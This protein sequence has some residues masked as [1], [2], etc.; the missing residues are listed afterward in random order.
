[1]R[2]NGLERERHGA[3]AKSLSGHFDPVGSKHLTTGDKSDKVI[4]SEHFFGA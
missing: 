4:G 2:K 1:M 3:G